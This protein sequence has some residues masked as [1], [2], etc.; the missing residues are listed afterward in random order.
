MRIAIFVLFFASLAG[1]VHGDELYSYISAG[2]HGFAAGSRVAG[3]ERGHASTRLDS[4]AGFVRNTTIVR[5][6]HGL[7]V[8]VAYALHTSHGGVA[9][10]LCQGLTAQGSVATQGLVEIQGG[11]CQELRLEGGWSRQASGEASWL[12][13]QAVASSVTAELAAGNR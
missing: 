1:S 5:T 3:G 12:R 11:A 13:G 10:H 8:N 6:P 9:R 2:P 4:R 7:V